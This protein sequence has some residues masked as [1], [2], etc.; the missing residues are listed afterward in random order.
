MIQLEARYD[1]QFDVDLLDRITLSIAAL[2]VSDDYRVGKIEHRWLND[3]GQAV[4]TIWRTEPFVDLA[5]FWFFTTNIG[6]TSNFAYCYGP[7]D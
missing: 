4:R 3:N 6:V 2:S 7:I 1:D 5:D